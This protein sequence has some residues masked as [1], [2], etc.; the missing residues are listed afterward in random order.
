MILL[1][2]HSLEE[3]F[4]YLH[5]LMGLGLYFLLHVTHGNRAPSVSWA[6]SFPPMGSASHDSYT[7]ASGT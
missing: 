3:C 7:S 5:P 4:L 6:L 2:V 1:A